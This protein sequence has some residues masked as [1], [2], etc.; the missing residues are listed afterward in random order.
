[1]RW[2]LPASSSRI[3]NDQFDLED[4]SVYNALSDGDEFLVSARL[5]CM[6]NDRFNSILS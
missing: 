5:V 4:E 2:S 3:D 6:I 1:M